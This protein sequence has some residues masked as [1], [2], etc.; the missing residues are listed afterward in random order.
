MITEKQ[1]R[2]RLARVLLEEESISDFWAW[3]AEATIDMHL[4]S[5][6][7]SQDLVM[8]VYLALA[9]YS[10]EH[11]DESELRDTFLELHN[12][13]HLPLDSPQP[14]YSGLSFLQPL[15]V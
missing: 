11:L 10:L 5:S 8:S 3:L 13:V 6:E 9:E 2:T 14:S 12:Q 1:V 15:Q 4:D 7:E